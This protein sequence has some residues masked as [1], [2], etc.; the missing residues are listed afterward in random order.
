LSFLLFIAGLSE[1]FIG[2]NP[3]VHGVSQLALLLSIL[4]LIVALTVVE[5][6]PGTSEMMV[7]VVI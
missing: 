1:L 4:P 6:D 3:L 2:A 7:F 5:F